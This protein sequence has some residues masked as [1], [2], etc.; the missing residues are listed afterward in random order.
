MTRALVSLL[1]A[2]ALAIGTGLLIHGPA[3][4]GAGPAVGGQGET[5]SGAGIEP[6]TIDIPE[7]I[8]VD[9][10][11]RL[12]RARLPDEPEGGRL[13][14]RDEPGLP[15]AAHRVLA[16]RVRLAGAGAPAQRVRA[17][18]DPHRRPRH[19]L[20]APPV[21]GARCLPADP[22]P[23]LARHLRGVRQGDRAADRSG[24]PRGAGG[25]RV[26]RRGAVDPGLRLFGS[27]AASGLRARPHRRHLRR[28]DGPVGIRAI[29]CAGRRPRRRHQPLAGRQ[30]RGACGR[31]APEPVQRRSARSGRPDGRSAARRG[32]ADARARR[33]LDRR[34]A[35]A[36]ATCTGPSRRPSATA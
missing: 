27:P 22:D 17:V 18:Q 4:A 35:R 20:R 36:T 5:S 15:A 11:E 12:M 31:P 10:R 21:A 34:G 1:A 23:R 19:P 7:K 25:G 24:R 29:H 13:A 16:R 33:V 6:F 9:L 26:P 14:A 3:S 8:L 28:A 2:T 32:R 30:R